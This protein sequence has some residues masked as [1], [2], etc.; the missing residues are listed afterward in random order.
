[1][2]ALGITDLTDAAFAGESGAFNPAFAPYVLASG[3]SPFVFNGTATIKQQAAY[4]QDDIRTGNAS[5]KLGVR[6]DHYAGLTI[7]TQVQPR[8]GASYN[9]SHSNTVLRASWGR[10]ME[11]PYNENL[12]LSSGF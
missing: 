3:G 11:T 6:L 4:L 1:S 12:L 5:F 2:F 9:I 10:T 7:D 8:L